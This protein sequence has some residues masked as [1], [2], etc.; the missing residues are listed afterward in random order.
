M[1]KLSFV[2]L[3]FTLPLLPSTPYAGLPLWAWASLLSS[4]FYALILIFAIETEWD[5]GSSDE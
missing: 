5:E 4:L 2:L 3:F 1:Y